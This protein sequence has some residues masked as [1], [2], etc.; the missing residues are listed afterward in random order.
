MMKAIGL[1]FLSFSLKTQGGTLKV[2]FEN[3]S[4]FKGKLHYIL[5]DQREGFPNEEDKGIKQGTISAMDAKEGLL[6][7]GL[8]EGTYALSVFH[9]ENSNGKLDTNFLGIPKEDFGFSNNPRIFFGPPSFNGSKFEFKT[10]QVMSI[11]MKGF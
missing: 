7:D 2:I 4:S 6:I 9:D 8:Q 3:L 1:L 5:F 11:K 10:D